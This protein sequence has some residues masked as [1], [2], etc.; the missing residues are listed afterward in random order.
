[1][2]ICVVTAKNL[3]QAK[4]ILEKAKA[5]GFDVHFQVQCSGALVTRGSYPAEVASQPVRDFFIELQELKRNGWPVA[6]SDAYLKYVIGWKDYRSVCHV[7][8]TKQCAA[9]HGF[10]YIDPRGQAYACLACRGYSKGVNLLTDRWETT[11][12]GN[13]PCTECVVGPY[14]E[15]NLLFEHPISQLFDMW[16]SYSLKKM[17]RV[18]D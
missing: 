11:W 9:G 18:S 12:D 1:M 15:F 10:I 14:L 17:M 2:A 6:S 16:Q 3:T 4:H 13:K 8:Q 7:D 5:I